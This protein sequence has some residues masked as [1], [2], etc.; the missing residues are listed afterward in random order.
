ME[1]GRSVCSN[2]YDLLS[3]TQYMNEIHNRLSN[4]SLSPAIRESGSH[5]VSEDALQSILH[6]LVP[7]IC[8]SRN[9]RFVFTLYS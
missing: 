8:C 5:H 4:F 2:V 9:C 6:A 1:C 7:E 3:Q